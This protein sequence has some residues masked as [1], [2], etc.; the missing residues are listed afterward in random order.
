MNKDWDQ[1]RKSVILPHFNPENCRPESQDKCAAEH[2][3]FF[4]VKCRLRPCPPPMPPLGKITKYK[5]KI[6]TKI[7]KAVGRIGLYE[8]L[9]RMTCTLHEYLCTFMEI[10]R[11]FLPRMRN[12][13]DKICRGNQ[14]TRFRFN[15]YP[16]EN[17]TVYE[18]MCK[19]YGTNREATDDNKIRRMLF[20]CWITKATDPHT[21]YV[22]FIVLQ[23][24]NSYCERACVFCLYVNCLCFYCKS[25]NIKSQAF[26]K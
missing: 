24:N 5:K 13:L 15:K 2:K 3:V 23:G 4:V 25:R 1:G 10:T 6:K 18:I 12:I 20:G 26:P 22:T 8:L 7:S 9:T 11:S 17:R 19:N 16:P 14:N 21:E